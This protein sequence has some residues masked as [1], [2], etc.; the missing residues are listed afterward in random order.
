M[1]FDS[2]QKDLVDKLYGSTD[3]SLT[4]KKLENTCI[5]LLFNTKLAP[6]H[7]LL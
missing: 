1:A 3:N 7:V 4:C 6:K 2:I 5:Q